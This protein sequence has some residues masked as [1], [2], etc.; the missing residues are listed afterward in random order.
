MFSDT[1]LVLLTGK[2]E[3]VRGTGERKQLVHI[4][5]LYSHP[6]SILRG[7]GPG[8]N[9]QPTKQQG[10]LCSHPPWLSK[11]SSFPIRPPPCRHCQQAQLTNKLSFLCCKKVTMWET[12]ETESSQGSQHHPAR[13]HGG[14]AR[15]I[16]H[17]A[18]LPRD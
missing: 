13:P 8:P 15:G 16:A 17:R 1:S 14:C 10:R 18:Q 2:R 6:K 7:R 11:Q 5:R 9:T 12:F 4:Y 3:K